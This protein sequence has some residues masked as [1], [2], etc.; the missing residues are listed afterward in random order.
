LSP[1]LSLWR[2]V[3][4]NFAIWTEIIENT[5]RRNRK[6]GGMLAY[7]CQKG[8]SEREKKT[9]C[10]ARTSKCRIIIGIRT[11]GRHLTKGVAGDRS[12]ELRGKKIKKGGKSPRIV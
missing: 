1:T 12:S 10:K 5:G 8:P 7:N 3:I 11:S 4:E 9:T 2:D 6:R